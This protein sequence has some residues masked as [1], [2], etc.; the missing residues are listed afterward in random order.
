MKK[1]LT[2]LKVGLLTVAAIAGF[3]YSMRMVQEGSM[4]AGD[5]YSAYAVMDNVLGI[6]KRS[7][8]VMAGIEIGFIESIELEGAKARVNL[9]IRKGVPLYRDALIAKISESILGD[10]LLDLAPGKEMDHPLPDGG[11]I[12]NVYEEKDF[13]EIYRQLDQITDNIRGVTESLNKTI[14]QLDTDDS[15]GGVMR[16]MVK[17]SENVA[18]LTERV[19][20]AFQEG[21]GKVQQILDDV[22]GVTAGT[23]GRYAQILD[24]IRDVSGDL[25]TLVAHLNDVVGRGGEDWKES[26]GSVKDT[27]ARASRSLENL[28]NITKKIDEGKGT[29]GRLVNDDKVLTK[30][31]GVLDDASSFTSKMARLQTII[32]LRSEYHVRQN[33]AKNYLALK[34]APKSDKYYLIEVID[35]PRGSV[36]VEEKCG[37]A[38]CTAPNRTKSVT[39]KDEFKFSLQFAKRYYWLGLRFGI[40]EGTGGVGMNGYFF[41]DDLEFKL[42]VFQ[43]GKNEYGVGAK[44]RVKAMVMYRPTWLANH[45]YIAGGGDDFF[46]GKEVFDYFIGAG[47]SFDDQD[48]K[49]I[50]M[51]TG[52]PNP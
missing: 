25:K 5:T 44:P 27:L 14:G 10:K 34:L 33:A 12:V 32:D 47:I 26:V 15:L 9:R 21:S 40:I 2:P 48:L 41:K 20:Q 17:I 23:R 19:N 29:L 3:V 49:S 4:G 8:V 50:F 46:N 45:L 37:D 28:D 13:T 38:T 11:R 6:A 51:T 30:A 18:M 16:R 39:I 22:A 43:F 35:D 1:L 31:E 7:R 36:S 24:N 52:V 42:D